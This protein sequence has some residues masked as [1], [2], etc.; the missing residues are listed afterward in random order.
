M[1]LLLYVSGVALLLV[2]VLRLSGP[3]KPAVHKNLDAARMRAM[4]EMLYFRGYDGAIL[5]IEVSGDDRFVQL[6]KLVRA[7]GDVTLRCDFPLV[8]WSEPYYEQ[9]K[10]YLDSAGIAYRDSAGPTDL[11]VYGTTPPRTLIITFGNEVDTAAQFVD[12]VFKRIFSVDPATRAVAT[13][14]NVDAR[15]VRIGF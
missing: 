10:G 13:V 2:V 14:E 8:Q 1:K 6:R 3:S 11:T 15:D 7:Q 4:I 9:V 12:H 5:F